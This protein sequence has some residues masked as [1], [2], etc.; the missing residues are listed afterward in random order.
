MSDKDNYR[1]LWLALNRVPHKIGYVDVDGVRT[2][3]IE[4]GDPDAPVVLGLHGTSGSLEAFATNVEAYSRH[5]RFL[6]IDMIGSGWTDKPDFPYMGADYA[7][8]ALGFLDAVGVSKASVV[9]V[10]LGA[11]AAVY[12]A[13]SARERVEKLVLV[14]PIG[15]VVSNERAAEVSAS[16]AKRGSFMTTPTW[17][18]VRGAFAQLFLHPEDVMDDMVAVRLAY[19]RT[20]EML[21]SVPNVLVPKDSDYL[22]DDWWRAFD[23]PMLVLANVDAPN[24]FLD[25]AYNIGRLAPNAELL[26][27]PGYDHHA[28]SEIPETFNQVTIEYLTR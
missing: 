4:A 5:F 11:L 20:P 28:Q 14:S 19:Y 1:S 21:K 10:S 25:N 18:S 15:T 2:R 7:E 17:E 23:V 27:L 9:G 22:P 6:A 3:Y 26:E 8:H 24:F 16:L 13:R 12:M